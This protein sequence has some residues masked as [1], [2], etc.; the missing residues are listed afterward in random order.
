MYVGEGGTPDFRDEPDLAGDAV[1]TGSF[2]HCS[3]SEALICLP[4]K[5]VSDIDTDLRNDYDGENAAANEADGVMS[6][7]ASFLDLAERLNLNS[8]H[9]KELA[10]RRT[11]SAHP[12]KI[13]PPSGN[14]FNTDSSPYLTGRS[15][16][17]LA[18]ANANAGYFSLANPSDRTDGDMT[19]AA[20]PSS[21]LASEHLLEQNLVALGWQFMMTGTAPR[22]SQSVSYDS[23][24]IDNRVPEALM[25]AN[26]V[27]RQ[28]W[29]TWDTL[30]PQGTHED[31]TLSPE[32]EMWDAI[33]SVGHPEYMVNLQ[34]IINAFKSRMMRGISGIRTTRWDNN[35]WDDTSDTT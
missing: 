15:G 16:Q 5:N 1:F 24:F 27:F 28:S 21:D 29:N 32:R 14:T 8:T 22:T 13:T 25:G 10:P 3:G 11:E 12:W 20:G 9:T 6:R 23:T 26:S 17:V 30:A 18:S 7:G 34:Q 19:D 35:V 33:G 4:P 2:M 31:A